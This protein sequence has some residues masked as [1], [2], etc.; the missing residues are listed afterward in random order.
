MHYVVD[1]SLWVTHHGLNW[2]M[3]SAAA[4]L[5]SWV[6]AGRGRFRNAG[7]HADLPFSQLK[8]SRRR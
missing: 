2:W 1:I 5:L 4:L 3:V 8:R 6:V 7:W